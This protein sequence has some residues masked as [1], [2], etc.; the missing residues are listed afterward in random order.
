[1]RRRRASARLAPPAATTR[2][3]RPHN[4]TA[5]WPRRVH[6][7][8]AD[9][10]RRATAAD[11][12]D[13]DGAATAAQVTSGLHT[14]LGQLAWPHTAALPAATVA[15]QLP[16][17][18]LQHA[19][20]LVRDLRAQHPAA[21]YVLGDTTFGSCC[22]DV[23]AARRVGAQAI[24]HYGRA[25][26]SPLEGVRVLHVL[27]RWPLAVDRVA[28]AVRAVRAATQRGVLVLYDVGYAHAAADLARAV[29]E[30]GVEDMVVSQL[31]MPDACAGADG[32]TLPETTAT[33]EVNGRAIALPPGRT[34][35]DY[36]SPSSAATGR[37]CG[38]LLPRLDPTASTQRP[39]RQRP[40]GRAAGA[41]ARR[42]YEASRAARVV[43]LLAGRWAQG[44]AGG[45]GEAA[46]G[47]PRRRQ[48]RTTSSWA[49]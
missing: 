32:A 22:V 8:G 45:H 34:I 42:H 49:D 37:C 18:L 25:C 23:E 28:E 16:D 30:R 3:A 48:R 10:L 6:A 27:P 31:R 4:V 20:G 9:A 41:A 2:Q 33:L 36:V 47:V 12:G 40:R 46:A 17:A 15:L 13:D 5:A 7:D 14:A 1:M 19:A 11:D 44:P 26:L 39:A 29:A 43:G 38:H 35:E 24:V 21:Y